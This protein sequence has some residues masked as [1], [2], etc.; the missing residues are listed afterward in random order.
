MAPLLSPSL[1]FNI[2][3]PLNQ[4]LLLKI[5]VNH[6]FLVEIISVSVAIGGLGLPSLETEQEVEEIDLVVSLFES[7]TLARYLLRDS[8][9]LLQLKSGLIT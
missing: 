5:K 3:Q 7:P 8:I 9:E 6:N 4:V 1:K 2:L